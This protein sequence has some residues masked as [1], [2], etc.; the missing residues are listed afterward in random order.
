MTSVAALLASPE[1]F[2]QGLETGVFAQDGA[3]SALVTVGESLQAAGLGEEIITRNLADYRAALTSGHP[4][5]A[6]TWAA[7]TAGEARKNSN[8][9][10]RALA[11]AH[12]TLFGDRAT[13]AAQA[14]AVLKEE[15]QPEVEYPSPFDLDLQLK[16]TEFTTVWQGRET[17][18]GRLVVIKFFDGSIEQTS[19]QEAVLAEVRALLQLSHPNI[20]KMLQHGEAFP[21]DGGHQGI[22][23]IVLEYAGDSMKILSE[24]KTPLLPMSWPDAKEIILQIAGALAAVHQAGLVH[25]DVGLNNILLQRRS[26]SKWIAKLCDFGIACNIGFTNP[27]ITLGTPVYM[28]PEQFRKAALLDQRTDIYGLGVLLFEMLTGR[29]P[30]NDEM[31][32]TQQHLNKPPP[33]P[34]TLRPYLNIPEAAEAIVLK[35]MAKKPEDRFQ[36]M[37]EMAEAIRAVE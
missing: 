32:E 17:A 28:A 33:H 18:S 5:R 29:S 24:R 11:G 26:D 13:A 34:R 31:V 27:Y 9:L 37:D 22:P 2:A 3:A 4:F 1:A 36:S 16:R 15:H 20:V 30:F 21:Y 19:R 12:F 8:P 14:R 6:K 10:R 35:A 23:Y 7:L 25:R